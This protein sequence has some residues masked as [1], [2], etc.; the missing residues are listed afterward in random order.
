MYWKQKSHFGQNLLLVIELWMGVLEVRGSK[1]DQIFDSFAFLSFPLLLF[2]LPPLLYS[3]TFLHCD[4]AFLPFSL[5][6]LLTFLNCVL[7]TFPFFLLP[8]LYPLTFLFC[9][10]FT[11]PYFSPSSLLKFC[12]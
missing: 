5:F 6:L 4:F 12:L 11:L 9:V 2:H 7:F 1:T 8:L 3:L 10:I